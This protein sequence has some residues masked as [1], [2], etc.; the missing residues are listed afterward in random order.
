MPESKGAG[1]VC[2]T[3]IGEDERQLASLVRLYGSDAAACIV[4]SHVVVVGIGGVGSWAAEALARSGVGEL[5]LIDFDHISVSNINRQVHALRS[6][7]GQSKVLAMRERIWA[8]NP[9]TTV[10]IVDDFVSPENWPSVLPSNAKAVVDCCDQFSAKLTMARWAI[11]QPKSRR[12][13]F[14]CVGAAGGKRRAQAVE[15]ADLQEVTHDPL[16]AKLRY[17]LRR[18][19]RDILER[20]AGSQISKVN[21]NSQAKPMGLLCVFSREAVQAPVTSN[22]GLNF[23]QGAGGGAALNCAGYGS[24][25]AVTATFGLVAA[26]AVIN[27]LVVP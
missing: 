5:T 14:I 15:L 7:L 19:Q 1:E 18:E 26:G 24:A 12:L 2:E 20:Q 17:A 9:S 25:V 22:K 13:A 16:L 21:A 10:H 6:T 4:R 8:I 23:E 11:A 3:S 27:S